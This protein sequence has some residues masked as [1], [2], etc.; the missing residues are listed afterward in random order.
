MAKRANK[1]GTVYKKTVIKNGKKYIYWEAQ[2]T[3]DHDPGSGKRIRKTYTG[4]TQQEAKNKMQDAS[5]A[6]RN[7]EYFEPSKATVSEWIDLWLKDYCGHIKYQ[8]KKSYR[9]QCEAHI[10]PNLGATKLSKLDAQQIQ[11]F[12][13]KLAVS[14]KSSGKP[15]SPKSI[16]NVHAILS[17]SMNTAIE[18]GYIKTNPTSRAKLPK[19]ERK[20][21]NPLTN[22][23][24]K[25]FLEQLDGELYAEL[26]TIIVFTGLRKAEASGLSW[27]CVDF[28]SNILTINKQLQKR[29]KKDGGYT[30]APLKND[31]IRVLSIP[32]FL[33]KVLEQQKKKQES[34]KESA[35]DAWQGYKD[36]KERKT[37]LVFT[38][39]LGGPINPKTIYLHY[40]K[41]ANRIDLTESRVHD[42]RHTYAVLALQNG[43]EVKTVQDNLGHATASFT[44]DVYG[45]TTDRM[46]QESANRMQSFYNKILPVTEKKTETTEE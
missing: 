23:E 7:D 2:V 35:G 40:K 38:T 22:E 45:H 25:L 30:L 31:K 9:A 21:I 32:P 18:I 20:E 15:L 14:G 6:I 10:K 13:N 37:S 42:L 3:V 11:S 44:L 41:I 39:P 1:E 33:S 16:K 34:F 4:K 43:D 8:T 27:D 46:K 5:V 19:V 12:Y 28:E 36:D 24:L 26:Y 17:K 29:P